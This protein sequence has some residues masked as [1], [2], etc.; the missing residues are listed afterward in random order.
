MRCPNC[1]YI[2]SENQYL[3]QF[4]D[5]DSGNHIIAGGRMV[6]KTT[7][8]IEDAINAAEKGETCNIVAPMERQVLEISD[9]IAKQERQTKINSRLFEDSSGGKIVLFSAHNIKSVG[10]NKNVPDRLYI[11][12]ADMVEND[13]IMSFDSSSKNKVDKLSLFYTP[14]ENST[15]LNGFAEYNDLY[16]TWHIPISSAPHLDD[17]Y[18]E[19]HHQ[20]LSQRAWKREMCAEY[21][22]DKKDV[23]PTHSFS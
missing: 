5:M 20:R 18:E 10:G 9:R 7:M 2:K 11:D 4:K 8:V 17:K 22:G 13:T 16:D 15:L 12:E 6:G 21:W 19:R 23:E 1:G 14:E 3:N